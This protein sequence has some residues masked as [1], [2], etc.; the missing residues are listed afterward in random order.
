MASIRLAALSAILSFLAPCFAH[1]TTATLLA[2]AEAVDKRCSNSLGA[3]GVFCQRDGEAA[4]PVETDGPGVP[5]Q[6]S[7]RS[8]FDPPN[9]RVVAILHLMPQ[10]TQSGFA[11]YTATVERYKTKLLTGDFSPTDRFENSV[12]EYLADSG[13]AST[14]PGTAAEK[15]YL[16]QQE[17]HLEQKKA[18]EDAVHE[19]DAKIQ[20]QRDYEQSPAGKEAAAKQAVAGCRRT[21]DV[22]TRAI[23]Q[24]K[25]VAQISGY[26]NASVREQAATAIVQCQDVISRSGRPST[27]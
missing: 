23:E 25:R 21:I 7:D 9:M 20:A 26:V 22:A 10:Q 16:A 27:Q 14:K 11:Y 5:V 19:R 1:A 17:A 12:W 15:N 2:P 3:M 18:R 6:A 24:D 4:P 13:I 8:P